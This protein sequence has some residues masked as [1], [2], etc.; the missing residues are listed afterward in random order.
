VPAAQCTTR[1]RLSMSAGAGVRD[2]SM[3][4]DSATGSCFSTV[5]SKVRASVCD[6]ANARS[7]LPH[8]MPRTVA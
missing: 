7:A 2:G 8:T 5:Y 4:S 6:P 3:A 1:R